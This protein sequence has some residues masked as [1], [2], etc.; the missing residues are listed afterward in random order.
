MKKILSLFLLAII[1]L[2]L[3]SCGQKKF[4]ME[5]DTGTNLLGNTFTVYSSSSWLSD[6]RKRGKNASYDRFIDRIEEIEKNYNV[7]IRNNYDGQSF[8]TKILTLTLKGG[9]GCDMIYCGNDDL[10][11]LYNLGI[12]TPFEE[13]GVKD[14]QAIK[15]GIPSLLV[16]GTFGGTQYGIINYLGDSIPSV[17]GFI[18][19]NMNL[20]TDLSMTDPHEYVERGE[21]NWANFRVV[22]QQGTFNDGETNHVAMLSDGLLC[23]VFGMFSA[24]LSN[25]GYIIKEIDGIYQS[26]LCETNAYEAMEF[27][28]GLVNDGLIQVTGGIE[29][30]WY[31]GKTWP[32]MNNGGLVINSDIPHSIVRFPYGPNGNQ[33][34][35][36]AYT[37]NRSY[38]AFTSLSS[39]ENDEIGIIVDDLF[40]P[41]D[42]S[43][44]PEGWK[45]YAI[46]NIFYSDADYDTYMTALDTMSYY[47]LGLLYGTNP[48]SNNG[49][50]EAA[51]ANI[52]MGR[53]TAQSEMESVK[54]ILKKA[55]DENLNAD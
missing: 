4:I 27:M 24:I 50:V 21:W 28:S 7:K 37:L 17:S 11:A 1:S 39:F 43:L 31:E 34:I 14:N 5:E 49:E 13:I 29:D 20:L 22:L 15:F 48:W 47:P 6:T 18:T 26:G 33:N 2:S 23:G 35:V 52:F 25:G 53:G 19:I 12:L 16:E 3:I 38:Y 36:A 32:M 54:D 45:D 10:Y 8:Q 40:E 9:G 41:L 42:K 55:I 44:Y 46:E 51:L 30:V